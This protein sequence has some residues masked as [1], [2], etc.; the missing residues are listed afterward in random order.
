MSDNDFDPDELSD[1]MNRIG[2]DPDNWQAGLTPAEIE[3]VNR[4]AISLEKRIKIIV[5]ESPLNVEKF[6]FRHEWVNGLFEE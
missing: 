3:Y 2:Y 5:L 6:Y 4:A 1:F